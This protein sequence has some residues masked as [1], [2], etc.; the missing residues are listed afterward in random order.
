VIRFLR[1]FT[2][3]RLQPPY[4]LVVLAA[5]TALG[6]VVTWMDPAE[7]DSGLGLLLFV[8]MFMV[9][10]GF[11]PRARA[12]HL[13]G[14]LTAGEDRVRVAAAHW[15]LSIL[16]GVAAWAIVVAVGLLAGSGV[17]WSAMAGRRAAG[18]MIVSMLAWVAGY[19]LPRG[20]A[21]V[22]WV[23][24]LLAVLLQHQAQLFTVPFDGQHG[25]LLQLG[26]ILVCPFLLI[27]S[28]PAVPPQVL[29]AAMLVCAAALGGA[30]LLTK[31]LDVL[32]VERT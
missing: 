3:L 10:T 27:G 23:T 28:R 1:F 32:L 21:G 18:W 4:T 22:A 20:A 24:V 29:G 11:V 7:L 17:A 25:V 14:L 6:A 13:D 9:S 26:A 5:C 8:Q 15:L 30:W 12:G 31:R 19:R 2:I 16:P